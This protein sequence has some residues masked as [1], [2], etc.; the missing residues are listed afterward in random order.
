MLIGTAVQSIRYE[1]IKRAKSFENIT[2]R[3]KNKLYF[4]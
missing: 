1:T 4:L 3:Q 2:L